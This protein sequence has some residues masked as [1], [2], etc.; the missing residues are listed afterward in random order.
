MNRSIINLSMS[1]LALLILL[2]GCKP[3]I[4]IYVST[5]GDNGNPG[6]RSGPVMTPEAALR[7]AEEKYSEKPGRDI[8]VIFGEGIY[9]LTQTFTIT[10]LKG[11]NNNGQIYFA[12]GKEDSVILS[13]GT[14][15]GNWQIRED[16]IWEAGIEPGIQTEQLYVNGIRAERARIP[17]SDA[18]QPMWYID[19]VQVSV[20][21]VTGL[22]NTIIIGLK[23]DKELLKLPLR[24]ESEIIIFKD[25]ATL[26]KQVTGIDT[27]SGFLNLKPP[28]AFFQGNYNGLMASYTKRFTC[29]LEGNPSFIDK[30]GEWAFDAM[31]NTLLYYPLPGEK[32]ESTTAIIPLVKTLV[33]L[34]GSKDNKVRNIHFENISFQHAAYLLPE[35]GHDGRQAC[36]YYTD[37]TGIPDHEALIEEAIRIEWAENC[38]FSGCEVANTGANGIYVTEGSFNIKIENSNISDI[39]GNGIMIGTAYDPK[40]DTASLVKNILISGCELHRAGQHY[41]SAV[42]IW[43]GFAAKC[44]ISDNHVYDLPY[45]GISIGWQWNPSPTSSKNNLIS[46]NHIHDVMKMLGDGGGIYTLGF[47]PGSVISDNEIHDILRSELNHASPNNG[48]FIDEGSKGYL[49][50][51]NHI[52]RVAHTCIRGHRAAGVELKHNIFEPGEFPAISHTPPYG[53]MIFANKDSTIVWPNPGWPEEWGYPDTIVAFRMEGN[54]FK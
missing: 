2:A 29:Y 11:D 25:W 50:K 20:N 5:A 6:T 33:S 13:G 19:S 32:P 24:G 49:V 16:G 14:R 3:D 27:T 41:Q 47:Q 1:I 48:M 43:Q 30:P 23:D 15:V 42:G 12:A 34:K 9:E 38:S 17:N 36:F 26:R 46:G 44:N 7:I 10:P 40:E 35:F 22:L 37:G 54:V 21:Q 8:R 18:G 52:Y 51:N 53:A 45:T 31:T 39:G 28:Y 4:K